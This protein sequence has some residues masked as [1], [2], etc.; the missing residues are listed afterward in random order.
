VRA[1]A[2]A[3][4]IAAALLST[5]VLG[6]CSSGGGSTTELCRA[7]SGGAFAEVFRQGFDPTDTARAL[8]QLK[9]AAV[10]LDE[11][12][13]A[14]PSAV[15]G[16][17]TDELAYVRAVTKVLQRVDPDDEAE[18]VARINALT[19]ERAAAQAASAKLT[20]YQSA[21]CTTTS[22]TS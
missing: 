1:R 14:A 6:A 2:A 12:H 7:A 10:D 4:A 19:S 15:R 18:V 9:T 3:A 11:L 20:A 5:T 13:A 16:A 21:H 22:T 17:V 8:A